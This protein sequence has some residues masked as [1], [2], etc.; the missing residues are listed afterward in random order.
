M[1]TDELTERVKAGLARAHD[2]LAVAKAVLAAGYPADAVSPAY[3]AVFHAAEALLLL[4]GDEPRSHEGLKSLFGLRFV[5]T[6]RLPEEM[7][8]ILR[9][10]KDERES[11]DY[12]I[13]PAI[14]AEE[15]ERA[16]ASAAR[17]IATLEAFLT[18]QGFPPGA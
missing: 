4:E 14:T 13:F 15:G 6:G 7:A 8:S 9:E 11:S 5:K 17:F 2:K 1:A 16:V 18:A 10:L 3:Y 12:S